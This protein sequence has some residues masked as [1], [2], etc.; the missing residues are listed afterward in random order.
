MVAIINLSKSS[1]TFHSKYN[2]IDPIGMVV[3]CIYRFL[4]E[5][6]LHLPTML[7]VKVQIDNRLHC[8]PTHSP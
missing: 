3:I 5:L 2:W 1:I 4:L 7:W 6:E 8:V